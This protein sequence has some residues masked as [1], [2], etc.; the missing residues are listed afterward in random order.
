M[1]SETGHSITKMISETLTWT[2]LMMQSITILVYTIVQCG[3]GKKDQAKA[4][5]AMIAAAVRYS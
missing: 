2:L 3:G 4:T 5:P 1:S